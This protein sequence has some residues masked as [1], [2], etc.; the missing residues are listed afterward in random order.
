MPLK[1][2]EETEFGDFQTPPDLAQQVCHLLSES[3]LVPRSIIE[4][5]CGQG[6]LL[7]EALNTFPNF[8]QAVGSDISPLYIIAATSHLKNRR[9]KGQL[10]L[11]QDDFFSTDWLKIVNELPEPILLIGTPLGNKCSNCVPWRQ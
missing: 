8:G 2:L 4:P 10:T 11:L 1:T 3:G 9:D 7:F 6:N 5:T